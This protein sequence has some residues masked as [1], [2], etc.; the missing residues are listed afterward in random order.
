MR[1]KNTLPAELLRKMILYSSDEGDLICDFF[2]GSFSTAKI[3][4]SLNRHSTGFEIN[5][6][7]YDYQLKQMGNIERGYMLNDLSSNGGNPHHNQRKRWTEEE[8]SKV[9][10]R[11]NAIKSSGLTDK[12]AY[13]LLSVEFGRGYFSMMNVVKKKR[14][15]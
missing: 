1:N 2:L 15:N 4:K 11:Y 10:E 7:I 5:K 13:Q 9:L 14:K 6:D 12:K 8:A 3:S